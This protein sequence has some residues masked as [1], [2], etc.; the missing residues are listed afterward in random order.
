[1]V[2]EVRTDETNIPDINSPLPKSEVK[3]GNIADK[4]V[5]LNFEGGYMS[6]NTGTLLLL[7]VESQIGLIRSMTEVIPDDRGMPVTLNT[8]S[9]TC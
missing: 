5:I 2:Q 7:D 1:M 6:S 3:L 9:P 4:P 8:P